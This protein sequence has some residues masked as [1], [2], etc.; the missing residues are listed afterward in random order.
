MLGRPVAH[1]VV[2]SG[3]HESL[4]DAELDALLAVYAPAC[5]TK[6]LGPR[7]RVVAATADDSPDDERAAEVAIGRMVSQRSHGTYIATVGDEEAQLERLA[8]A[9]GEAWSGSGA[10]GS[11]SA[12]ALRL[13]PRGAGPKSSTI[14]RTVGAA[15]AAA[16]AA[17][18]LDRAD[19]VVEVWRDGKSLHALLRQRIDVGAEARY[20]DR[21]VEQRDHFS[22][23]GLH[24]R[25]AAVLVNLARVTPG[26]VVYDPFC[27]TGG[28]VLEAALLGFQAVGSDRDA[29]MVQGTLATLADA[30]P[31]GALEGLVYQADIGDAPALVPRVVGGIV[32]DLPYGRASGTDLEPVQALYE[33]AVA[34]FARML[35]AGRR[36]V[37][38]LADP[39]LLRTAAESSGFRVVEHHPEYVHRSLTRH[40][41]VLEKQ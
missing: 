19:W 41:L 13:G 9:V 16:G 8:S 36:A 10:A 21:A 20:A 7:V 6:N 31:G 14:E 17:I 1:L 25:R 22:P 2:L 24:P 18:D 39:E 30:A 5:S 29:W 35:A 23:I 40:W 34:A 32:A 4:P 11:V 28:I 37:V 15:L 38:G 33:R 27:G 12:R 26:D 3:D